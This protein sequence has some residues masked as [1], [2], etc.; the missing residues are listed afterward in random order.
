MEIEKSL[1]LNGRNASD[2]F[3]LMLD[4]LGRVGNRELGDDS[5]NLHGK[6]T[7]F[8]QVRTGVTQSFD[9]LDEMC[10][11]LT[12]LPNCITALTVV[13]SIPALIDNFHCDALVQFPT[14][15]AENRTEGLG[16]APL[17][18]DHLA[19]VF[20]MHAEFEHNHLLSLD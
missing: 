3:R 16:Y 14:R 1:V 19:E 18:A 10:S 17:A 13:R 11:L 4:R 2:R 6:L 5:C 8:P 15:C 20:R 9:C 12:T 7:C